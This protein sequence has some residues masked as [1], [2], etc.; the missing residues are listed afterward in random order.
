MLR[1]IT[2]TLLILS[3][4]ILICCET[5]P[6]GLQL[7]C[8]GC[9]FALWGIAYLIWQ[10]FEAAERRKHRRKKKKPPLSWHSDRE[11]KQMYIFILPSKG[12]FVNGC[13]RA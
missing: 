2:I 8:A 11:H 13:P 5:D 6:I 12:G 3:G 10:A 9:G 7:V 4:L 1:D